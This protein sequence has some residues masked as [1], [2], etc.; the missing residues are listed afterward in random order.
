[1]KRVRRRRRR[2]RTH[3]I[4]KYRQL[5]YEFEFDRGNPVGLLL[6]SEFYAYRSGIQVGNDFR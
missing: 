4:S 6:G 2:A 1:M 5:T 3:C